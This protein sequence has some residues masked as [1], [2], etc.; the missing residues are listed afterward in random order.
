VTTVASFDLI[1]F[2]YNTLITTITTPTL[3][4]IKTKSESI[5]KKYFTKAYYKESDGKLKRVGKVFKTIGAGIAYPTVRTFEVLYKKVGIRGARLMGWKDKSIKET[6]MKEH[7]RNLKIETLY[8]V[9]DYNKKLVDE[10]VDGK[11]KEF[12]ASEAGKKQVGESDA[13]YKQRF[14]KELKEKINEANKYNTKRTEPEERMALALKEI[15]KS[16]I[17]QVKKE[18]KEILKISLDDNELGRAEASAQ[19][20]STQSTESKEYKKILEAEKKRIK[21]EKANVKLNENAQKL[22]K[23]EDLK[24][25]ETVFE[26]LAK[27]DYSFDTDILK[28]FI[29]SQDNRKLLNMKIESM[30]EDEKKKLINFIDLNSMNGSRPKDIAWKIKE[31]N[32][33]FNKFQELDIVKQSKD[34]NLDEKKVH[35]KDQK[36]L[37]KDILND[38]IGEKIGIIAQG[39]YN[40]NIQAED[41]RVV[42]EAA[43]AAAAVKAKA[44]A[45]AKAA[46]AAAAAAA[47]PPPPPAGGADGT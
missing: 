44:E 46:A 36:D 39:V 22:K 6:A 3:K 7:H 4:F 40:A 45:D 8:S 23:L 31:N 13:I 32:S 21:I 26:R 43:K 47:A 28:E 9:F 35:F 19:I 12:L 38:E 10:F 25:G 15:K 5:L 37:A 30:Q 24:G 11:G 2:Y 14:E 42:E 33:F 34:N 27:I 41:A 16:A 18:Q 29:N 17:N 20:R 1:T